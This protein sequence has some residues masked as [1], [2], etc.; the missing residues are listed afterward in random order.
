ME[1][2]TAGT[3]FLI[4]AIAKLSHLPYAERERGHGQTPRLRAV[5]VVAGCVLRQIFR[6]LHISGDICWG[7]WLLPC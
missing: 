5:V 6:N 1:V 7:V 4:S 2:G 3:T